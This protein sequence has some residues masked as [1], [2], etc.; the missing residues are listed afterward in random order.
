MEAKEYSTIAIDPRDK[1]IARSGSQARTHFVLE[2]FPGRGLTINEIAELTGLK[3]SSAYVATR[4]LFNA[5]KCEKIQS[6]GTPARYRLL[7]EEREIAT[8]PSVASPES[9]KRSRED[10]K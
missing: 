10:L 8:M 6:K 7:E 4:D 5:Q 9:T 2:K 1:A 3:K